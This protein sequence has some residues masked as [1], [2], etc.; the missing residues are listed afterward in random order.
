[1]YVK[2][3][4]SEACGWVMI[5]EVGDI[6]TKK[7]RKNV[8]EICEMKTERE[9]KSSVGSGDDEMGVVEN[10]LRWMEAEEEEVF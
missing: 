3:D 8:F 7:K 2:G 4:G 6:R 1:M 9:R 10:Q 5:L